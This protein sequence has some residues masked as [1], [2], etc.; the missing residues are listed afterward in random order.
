MM[1]IKCVLVEMIIIGTINKTYG[2]EMNDLLFDFRHMRALAAVVECGSFSAG[3]KRLGQ[4]Q[5]AVSQMIADMEKNFSIEVFDRRKRPVK[6]TLAGEEVYKYA[7]KILFESK[8]MQEQFYA[9]KK[10]QL[11]LLRLGVVDSMTQLLVFEVLELLAPRV[12][13]IIQ[14]TGTAPDLLN[15]LQ[16]GKIDLAITAVSANVPE[17][18]LLYPL[19]NEKY[20]VVTPKAWPEMSLE[21]LCKDA[22]YVAYAGWTPTG[23]QTISWLKWR[24]IKPEVQ[25][26]LARADTVLNMIAAGY[27]WTLATPIFLASHVSR[28]DQFN[29]QLLPNPGQSRNVGLLCREGEF[30][31]FMKNFAI[32]LKKELLKKL[33]P[34]FHGYFELM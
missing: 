4:T 16:Q 19:V 11:P 32:D 27:G 12:N 9:I 6:L 24:L 13:R 23:E 5:S 2:E 14:I 25:F 15:A 28:L 20:L 8:Q 10:G 34:D 7:V 33:E 21:A 31:D 30:S 22:K 18:V 29:M 3:A 1:H 17:N 26:E